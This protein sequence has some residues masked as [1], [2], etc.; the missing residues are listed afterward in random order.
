MGDLVLGNFEEVAAAAGVQALA[1]YSKQAWNWLFDR[2]RRE[3]P[4][5]KSEWKGYRDENEI[6]INARKLARRRKAKAKALLA[7]PKKGTASYTSTMPR[8]LKRKRRIRR[9]RGSYAKR[10]RTVKRRYARKR[11]NSRRPRIGRVMPGHLP[12]KQL[13]RLKYLH[14]YRM[15]CAAGD[16]SVLRF[17]ACDVRKPVNAIGND[18]DNPNEF[19]G[20]TLRDTHVLGHASGIHI[21]AGQ[22]EWAKLT[23]KH[24]ST[25]VQHQPE[26]YDEAFSYYDRML[27]L[28]TTH[29]ITILP[30]SGSE[31]T[32]M[33]RTIAGW[34]KGQYFEPDVAVDHEF[35]DRWGNIVYSDVSRLIQNKVM[36]RPQFIMS[37]TE[38]AGT[39]TGMQT[40]TKTWDLRKYQKAARKLPDAPVN[41]DELMEDINFETNATASPGRF[42]NQYFIMGDLGNAS[43]NTFNIWIEV[44]YLVEMRKSDGTGAQPKSVI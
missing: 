14:Q 24:G 40:F 44:T 32:S 33:S 4:A 42:C 41:M 30:G 27:P 9:R 5:Q 1:P 3:R 39:L 38:G 43:N 23:D 2:I 36:E 21:K 35:G 12:Q 25:A 8:F 17:D 11:R 37:G 16:W 18:L 22:H 13:F 7:P 6:R 15:S 26:G 34:A 10:R 19:D 28:K 29:K 31:G 20:A